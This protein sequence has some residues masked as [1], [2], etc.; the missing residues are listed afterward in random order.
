MTVTIPDL[1]QLS[2]P[3]FQPLW[4]WIAGAVTIWYFAVAVLMR[5]GGR[6]KRIWG[7]TVKKQT[8]TDWHDFKNEAPDLWRWFE[9]Q[10]TGNQYIRNGKTTARIYGTG[11]SFA[12]PHGTFTGE[13]W[14]YADKPFSPAMQ[15]ALDLFVSPL[16]WL[17]SRPIEL[18]AKTAM[19]PFRLLLWIAKGSQQEPKPVTET[20]YGRFGPR[21]MPMQPA[22]IQAEPIKANSAES[23][24][25]GSYASGSLSPPFDPKPMVLASGLIM[26]RAVFSGQIASGSIGPFRGLCSG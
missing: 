26:T 2:P 5:A 1:T 25:V 15:V 23:I 6:G 8:D 13:K 14:R 22:Q 20:V 3:D 4:A 7:E 16:D 11:N 10:L 21:E 17:V 24:S 9:V 12:F 19:L 18:A